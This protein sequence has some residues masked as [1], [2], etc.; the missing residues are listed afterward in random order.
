MDLTTNRLVRLTN[1]V[2][3]SRQTMVIMCVMP[4]ESNAINA[5]NIEVDRVRRALKVPPIW[6]RR[7][8]PQSAA[9]PAYITA[10]DIKLP[11]KRTY[12]AAVAAATGSIKRQSHITDECYRCL[13]TPRPSAT[14]LSKAVF[15]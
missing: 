14:V 10:F 1:A 9:Q 5:Q 8:H 2:V 13:S 4:I 3:V 7:R 12:P 11:H 6:M 15:Q